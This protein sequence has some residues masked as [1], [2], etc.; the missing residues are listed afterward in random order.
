MSEELVFRRIRP[1]N[2]R[3]LESLV[4]MISQRVGRYLERQGLLVRNIDHSY[5]QLECKT[6]STLADLIGPSISYRIA[7]GP[8]AGRKAFTLQMVLTRGDSNKDT[9]W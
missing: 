5:L 4:Q 2:P 6:E 7:V 8:Q 1:P 9:V 3:D